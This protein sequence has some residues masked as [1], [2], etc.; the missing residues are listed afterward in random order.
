VFY[1][2]GRCYRPEASSLNWVRDA[3]ILS[4]EQWA[5]E[6]CLPELVFF[7]VKEATQALLFLILLA[8]QQDWF[9]ERK[10]R[11]QRSLFAVAALITTSADTSGA[12]VRRSFRNTLR[13]SHHWTGKRKDSDMTLKPNSGNLELPANLVQPR[14]EDNSAN[15]RLNQDEIRRRAYEIYL[16]RGGLSGGAFDDWLQAERELEN[17][18]PMGATT[19]EKHT[20]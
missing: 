16:E 2:F 12:A 8:I 10:A 5:S 13:R 20:P 9:P 19:G 3:T 6:E 17:V 15:H 1:R 14:A 4:G 7:V 18:A 11:P